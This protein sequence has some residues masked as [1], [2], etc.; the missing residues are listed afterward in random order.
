MPPTEKPPAASAATPDTNPLEAVEAQGIG[1]RAS[2]LIT[3]LQGIP[4]QD[5]SNIA[6][7]LKELQSLTEKLEGSKGDA[8][9]DT[10]ASNLQH[11][12]LTIDYYLENI[13]QELSGLEGVAGDISDIEGEINTP[14]LPCAKSTGG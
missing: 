5:K 14:K 13:R 10:S 7:E 2:A 3:K 4:E 12:L 8:V 1:A 11:L 9:E 6:D